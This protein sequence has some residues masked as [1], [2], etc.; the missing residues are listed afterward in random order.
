[1]NVHEEEPVEDVEQVDATLATS[2]FEITVASSTVQLTDRKGDA[3]YNTRNL[4]SRPLRAKAQPVPTPPAVASWF[5]VDQPE[6]DFS[7]GVVQQIPVHVTVPAAVPAGTYGF[8]L[9]VTGVANPDEQFTQGP[10]VTFT[11]PPE[12]IPPPP[13]PWWKRI[14]WW[15]YVAVAVGVLII[16]GVVA[17]LLLR[18]VTTPS[19]VGQTLPSAQATL[20]AASLK[21]GNTSEDVTGAPEQT[22]VRQAPGAATPA[23]RNSTV[24]LVVEAARVS[25]PNVVGRA[26]ADATTLLTQAGLVVGSTSEQPTGKPPGTVIQQNPPAGTAALRG[27][28]V[29]LV[30]EAPL[31][32]VPNVVGQDQGSA[33]ANIAQAGLRVGAVNLTQVIGIRTGTVLQQNPPGGQQVIRGSQVNLVVATC[34]PIL[35]NP[36]P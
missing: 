6:R 22:V 18:N 7:P 9:D 24:D 33:Q 8:R 29:N 28:A 20:Q 36:C 11:V 10:G 21:V 2:T 1:M 19:V 3:S 5:V 13:P 23:A 16:A 12:V 27:S 14:P 4:T 17:F 32:T 31:A 34:L 15:V 30:L 26:R 35:F 25:V